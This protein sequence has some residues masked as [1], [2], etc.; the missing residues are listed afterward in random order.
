VGIEISVSGKAKTEKFRELLSS[1]SYLDGF[2]ICVEGIGKS[3]QPA[4][5][6]NLRPGNPIPKHARFVS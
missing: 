1:T 4:S 6:P 3:Q 2:Q 5:E